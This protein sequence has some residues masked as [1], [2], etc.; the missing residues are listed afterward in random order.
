MS[1]P[2]L[3]FKDEAGRD[4]PDWAKKSIGD[5]VE[6][7]KGGAPLKPSDFVRYGDFEVILIS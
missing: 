2:A 1:A 3:R 5:F 4:F 6:G 7:H